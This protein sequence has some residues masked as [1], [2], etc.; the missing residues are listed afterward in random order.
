MSSFVARILLAWLAL[1]SLASP[2]G[3]AVDIAFYSRELGG[4]N[5]PHAFV[6]LDGTL[7]A[8]G[9]RIHAS[10]GFTA[11]AVTPALLF[12]SVAGEVIDESPRQVARSIRQFDL[13]LSDDQYRA[14]MA[15]V[16]EW[17]NRP[18]PSYNLNRRNC[19]HFVAALAAAA[20]V[21]VDYPR[22]LMKR[23]RSYL[24]HIRDLNPRL[25]APR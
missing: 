12:G 19:I 3:A 7:D 5:F 23:P 11:K 14:V 2:A 13:T 4:N 21:T 9:E 25:V 24:E 6:V 20:G 16:E 10:Y 1:W 17:R 22:R 18:Q 15:V 8:T